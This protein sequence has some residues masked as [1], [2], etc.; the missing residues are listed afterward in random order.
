[1]VELLTEQT[2]L[3]IIATLAV[4]GLFV[5][6]CRARRVSTSVD[7]AVADALHRMSK[8]APDLRDGLTP[9]ESARN[10]FDVAWK[11]I[12]TGCASYIRR[13]LHA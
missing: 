10:T 1:M 2:V 8:A 11:T 4:L 6:L 7:E 12:N 5:L 9:D 13:T 3:G